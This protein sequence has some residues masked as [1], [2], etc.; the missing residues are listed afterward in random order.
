MA[1]Y[2]GGFTVR[3][4]NGA[5]DVPAVTAAVREIFA[6]EEGLEITQASE[7]DERIQASIDVIVGALL[8]TALLAG[9]AGLVAI[10]QAFA[11][12]ARATVTASATSRRSA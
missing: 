3:L 9:V 7:V 12:H 11:R 10:G 1:V 8:V 4:Q 6:D 2:P 5:D